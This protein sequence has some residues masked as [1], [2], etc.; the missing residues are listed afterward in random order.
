MICYCCFS[1]DNTVLDRFI[2]ETFKFDTNLF[3]GLATVLRLMMNLRFHGT[4][5]GTKEHLK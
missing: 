2:E 1:Q 5:T 4:F 3:T